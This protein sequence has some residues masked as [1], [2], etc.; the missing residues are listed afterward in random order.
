MARKK[1]VVTI[2][3][4]PSDDSKRRLTNSEKFAQ[5]AINR[6]RT[7]PGSSQVAKQLQ[8]E[9]RQIRMMS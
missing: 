7:V 3:A 2:D 1:I 9:F 4:S 6:G 5:S 8:E